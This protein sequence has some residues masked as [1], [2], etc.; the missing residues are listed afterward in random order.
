MIKTI[1]IVVLLILNIGLVYFF[2]FVGKTTESDD[3]RTAIILNRNHSDYALMEM[4]GFLESIQQINKGIMV[5]D[6]EMIAEAGGRSG[7][8]V[9][10]QAPP[11]MM[12]ALP[13]GFKKLGF[14]TH[15]LFDVISQTTSDNYSPDTAREQMASLLNNCVVCHRNYKI[16]VSK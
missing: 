7:G 1:L 6:A 8:S 4:R 14:A 3:N 12:K 15:D 11:G 13:I 10:A 16:E 5:N 9:V 2:V